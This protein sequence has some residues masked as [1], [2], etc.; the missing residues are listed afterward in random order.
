M[1][2]AIKRKTFATPCVGRS[3]KIKQKRVRESE[4]VQQRAF[5]SVH[6]TRLLVRAFKT[7]PYILRTRVRESEPV[8]RGGAQLGPRGLTTAHYERGGLGDRTPQTPS[9]CE[10]AWERIGSSIIPFFLP[11][12]ISLGMK[13]TVGGKD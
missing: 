4:R 6:I 2:F 7:D 3:G 12:A 11:N 9:L 10:S 1:G 5:K 13:K 8:I